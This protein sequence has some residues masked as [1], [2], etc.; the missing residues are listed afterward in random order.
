MKSYLT[1]V[2]LVCS[3]AVFESFR[4]GMEGF[5]AEYLLLLIIASVATPHSINLGHEARI[6]TVQPLILLAI[7][8]YGTGE[9]MFMAAVCMTYYWI[10]CR[11]RPKPHQ[12]VF[13]IANYVLC[14]WLGGH[15]YLAAG[16]RP[17]DVT[18]MQSLLALLV[19][20]ALIFL[21]NTALVSIAVSLDRRINVFTVWY[22]KYSWTFSSYLAAASFVIVAILLRDSVGTVG[23]FVV[24]PFCVLIYH[25]YRVYFPRA[26]AG[27]HRT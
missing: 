2:L 26:A 19:T 7:V 12:A 14:G 24:L 25:F 21:L 8:L 10:V 22:E 9:A 15:A 5:G 18:S 17:A 27:N 16:G 23:V 3:A 11:P 1:T 4:H 13:N 20:V 6:S